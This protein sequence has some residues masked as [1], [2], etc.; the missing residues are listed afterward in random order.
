MTEEQPDIENETVLSSDALDWSVQFE[1]HFREAFQFACTK[2]P[3]T[4]SNNE[5]QAAAI[6]AFIATIKDSGIKDAK[7]IEL[8]G[9]TLW[10]PAEA[11]QAWTEEKNSR[12]MELIDK[13]FRDSIT[14][15]ERFELGSLTQ[16]MR[17]A[18]DTE[19]NTPLSGAKK[20]YSDLLELSD[21]D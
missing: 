15:V 2:L 9:R 1:K 10:E 20:L 4:A 3:S 19:E 11:K 17:A 13:M 18:L 5:F 12:R 21:D 7:L 16:A 6:E 14:N 8:I